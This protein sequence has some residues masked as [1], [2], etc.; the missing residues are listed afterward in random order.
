MA[1]PSKTLPPQLFTFDDS[2]LLSANPDDIDATF[3]DM[4]ELGIANPP[5]PT[6]DLQ[7]SGAQ[8]FVPLPSCDAAAARTI[9]TWQIRY[10][11]SAGQLQDTAIGPRWI[12]ILNHDCGE[13]FC[14]QLIT[15][16]FEFYKLLLVSLATRNV[17]KV[18]TESKLGRLGIG[19]PKHR[20][21]TLICIGQLAPVTSGEGTTGTT[22][23][24]HLRRGHI[25]RQ[26]FGP[27]LQS[28]RK[29]WIAPLFVNAEK[30]MAE[31]RKAYQLTR[32]LPSHP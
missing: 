26:P 23:R 22:K 15:L 7:L 25:R 12:S 3:A 32:P 8:L 1:I 13:D 11:F 16:G 6:F 2:L 21:T 4:E 18:T 14:D 28:V 20:F 10:R 19:K 30:G 31:G 29:I 9:M 24:P 17:E 5:V 27:S